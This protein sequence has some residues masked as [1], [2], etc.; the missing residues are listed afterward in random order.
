MDLSHGALLPKDIEED[1][2]QHN[3]HNHH[4]QPDSQEGM[5]KFHLHNQGNFKYI[6]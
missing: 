4:N 5:C 6:F 2:N 3:Q 1:E